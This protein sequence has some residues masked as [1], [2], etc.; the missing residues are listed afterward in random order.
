MFIFLDFIEMEQQQQLELNVAF[1]NWDKSQA[2]LSG[3][4]WMEPVL[5]MRVTNIYLALRKFAVKMSYSVLQ[6]NPTVDNT[7]RKPTHQHHQLPIVTSV[8]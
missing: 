3:A 2:R 7:D 4:G 6:I 1:L 8:V 5:W